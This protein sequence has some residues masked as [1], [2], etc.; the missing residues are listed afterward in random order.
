MK[1]DR[2][3]HTH[4]SVIGIKEYYDLCLSLCPFIP[5]KRE[6]ED[7]S[8]SLGKCM[9]ML[10]C[11]YVT[12]SQKSTLLQLFLLPHHAIISVLGV[13]AKELGGSDSDQ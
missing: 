5:E 9:L 1:S 12:Q 10:D 6:V 7:V 4:I 11:D 13:R 3:A 2:L 8:I